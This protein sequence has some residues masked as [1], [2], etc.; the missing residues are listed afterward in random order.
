MNLPVTDVT[1]GV[2]KFIASSIANVG[3][4][5]FKDAKFAQMFGSQANP[6]KVPSSSLTLFSM[7]DCLTIFAS[8]N[9]PTLMGPFITRQLS[10]ELQQ[11]LNGQTIAQFTAPATVQLLSTPLHL[12]GLDLY[13][14]QDPKIHWRQRWVVIKKN[15]AISSMARIARI[16]PA[17]G[18]GGV[19]NAGVRESLME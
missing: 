16:I 7:R 12:L 8:F 5:L 13:N 3:L 15:W 1:S 18:V 14:R 6:L 10:P 11:Y 9:V 2:A 17:F 19:V 4:S